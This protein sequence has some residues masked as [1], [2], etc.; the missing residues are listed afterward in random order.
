MSDVREYAEKLI[1][2]A[3]T[4]ECSTNPDL[5]TEEF[6][7]A[8]QWTAKPQKHVENLCEKLRESANVIYNISLNY[9]DLE[10]ENS[11]LI[12]YR[13]DYLNEIKHLQNEISRLEHELWQKSG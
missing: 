10:K 4:Y 2:Y 3:D 13:N 7:L 9:A 8:V 5:P 6:E 11:K 1:A 12:E